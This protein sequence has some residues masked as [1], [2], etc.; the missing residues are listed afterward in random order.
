MFAHCILSA[1]THF[2]FLSLVDSVVSLYLCVYVFVCM[3]LNMFGSVCVWVSSADKVKLHPKYCIQQ[4]S[5][6]L[7]F[8][9]LLKDL[10]L[11]WLSTFLLMPT[12]KALFWFNTKINYLGVLVCFVY[13]CTSH[14]RWVD[15]AGNESFG[16]RCG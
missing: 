12:L 2:S 5:I 10:F 6:L 7:C 4:E 8:C 9:D 1:V 3:H 14:W 15:S 11:C 16:T 13:S